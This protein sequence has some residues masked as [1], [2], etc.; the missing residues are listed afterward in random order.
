MGRIRLECAG[1]VEEIPENISGTARD[2]R[3]VDTA[4]QYNAI[5]ITSDQGV[6]A[7]ANSKNVFYIFI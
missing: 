7:Y 1:K 3:I 2:E 4:L 6:K 5:L